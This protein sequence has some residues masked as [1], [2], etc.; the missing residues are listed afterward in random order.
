[1]NKLNGG[2]TVSE[3]FF[4]MYSLCIKGWQKIW[5]LLFRGYAAAAAFLQQNRGKGLLQLTMST[6]KRLCKSIVINSGCAKHV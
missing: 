3:G 1:M 2:V 6:S 4:A 5:P